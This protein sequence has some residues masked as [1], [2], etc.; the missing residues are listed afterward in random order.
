MSKRDCNLIVVGAGSAGLIAALI[1]ANARAKVTLIESN[2][3]GGD[4]LNTGC[5][6]SKTLIASSRVA[7]TMRNARE[8]GFSTEDFEV[9]FG[10]IRQRIRDAIAT[11]EPND[12]VERYTQMGV[13]CLA[14]RAKV[15][16]PHRVLVD[17]RE[18]SARSIVLAIGAEPQIPPIPG[19][20]ESEPLTSESIWDLEELPSRLAVIGGGPVGCELAQAYCR[21]GSQV[22]LIESLD[23]LLPG[24]DQ[25]ASDLIEKTFD[26]EGV[27][28]HTGFT[29]KSCRNG[30]LSIENGSGEKEIGFDKVLV[31]TG[32]TP[33]GSDMGLE[34]I[35]IKMHPNRSIA[36]N[37]YMQT[38]VSSIYACGDVVGPYQFTHMAAQ[39]GWYAAMNALLRP[40]W[41]FKLDTRAA[42]WAIFTDPEVARAGLDERQLRERNIP[43]EVTKYEFADLDRAIA[44][45]KTSGFV[46][47]FTKKNSDQLLG[48]CIVGPQAGDLIQGCIDGMTHGYGLNKVLSTLHVYPTRS[49]ALRF[50][51]GMR[52]IRHV[53]EPL[54][55]L[56]KLVN[57][58]RR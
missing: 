37:D 23:R 5:I 55:K 4:C 10:R 34:E 31:A 52:R 16:D 27:V 40:F 22:T 15:V 14:G 41:R 1:G 53:P 30:V 7:H 43:H 29:A 11:I 3:M 24:E 20:K 19:L 39:Q 49:E 26:A 21:L 47:L 50:A 17:D 58:L 35:G 13:E 42:P 45:G 2:Q 48:A 8:Y 18:I 51:A 56:A 33:R 9:D 6:P 54:A 36:V 57:D 28:V 44:E 38:N 32:R 25:E 12:S 46:K